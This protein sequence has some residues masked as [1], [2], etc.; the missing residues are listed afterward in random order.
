MNVKTYTKNVI[1]V[2]T[3][4]TVIKMMVHSANK[5]RRDGTVCLKCNG[6]T[7]QDISSVAVTMLFLLLNWMKVKGT[8]LSVSFYVAALTTIFMTVRLV[9]A[10]IMYV[11]G[12]S[13]VSIGVVAATKPSVDA[14][15]TSASIEEAKAKGSAAGAKA[16]SKAAAEAGLSENEVIEAT[17]A[18]SAAGAVVAESVVN[19]IKKN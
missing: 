7:M 9:M 1:A 16:A 10:F 11:S 13:P 19:S 6:V 15:E 3:V 8:V 2:V 14:A 18:G 17:M 5:Y 12:Q 4:L